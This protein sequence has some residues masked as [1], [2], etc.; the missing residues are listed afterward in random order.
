MQL[1]IKQLSGELDEVQKQYLRH[2]FLW[3][4]ERL[5]NSATLTVGVRE[6][7]TKR[8]NQAF[9]IILHLIQ[10]KVKKPIYVRV[11]GNDFR[12]AAD[13]GKEKLE[14]IIIKRK[15]RGFLRLRLPKFGRKK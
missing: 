8:S 13:C 7:I 5:G 2:R 14:R 12:S 4:K 3:L 9:E 15:D 11:T 6:H 10:P 1:V